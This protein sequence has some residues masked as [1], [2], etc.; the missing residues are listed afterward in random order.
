MAAEPASEFYCV[1]LPDDELKPTHF[2]QR[3]L[4]DMK[5]MY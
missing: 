2:A 4:K 3:E 5:N 1:C